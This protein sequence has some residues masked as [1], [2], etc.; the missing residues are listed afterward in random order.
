MKVSQF[1]KLIREEVRRALTESKTT[2]TKKHKLRENTQKRTLNEVDVNPDPNDE[3][4]G[5]AEFDFD[6]FAKKCPVVLSSGDWVVSYNKQL[7]SMELIK[8]REENPKW[9]RDFI[10]LQNY[11]YTKYVDG[12]DFG[13]MIG[14]GDDIFNA[15]AIKNLKI[16][17]DPTVKKYVKKIMS[18]GGLELEKGKF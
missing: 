1:R 14:K 9:D 11:L 7:N 17:Q 13:L 12:T 6:T 5:S 16:L 4:S 8:K 2:K 18:Y 10:P 3:V 15:L